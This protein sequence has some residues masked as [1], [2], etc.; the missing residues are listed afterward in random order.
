[1]AVFFFTT[2]IVVFVVVVMAVLVVE[3][4]VGPGLVAEELSE[5]CELQVSAKNK[6]RNIG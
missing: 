3:L 4:G 2:A 1:M 5:V 6:I